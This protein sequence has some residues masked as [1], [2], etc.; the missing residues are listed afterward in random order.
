MGGFSQW[1]D[2]SGWGCST[3]SFF[4]VHS[5]IFNI[6]T[7]YQNGAVLPVLHKNT[8]SPPTLSPPTTKF[9]RISDNIFSGS[10]RV[11]WGNSPESLQQLTD[12][13]S[14]RYMAH[15]F[16]VMDHQENQHV[17]TTRGKK[18]HYK[19]KLTA[20]S[21]GKQFGL[22][23]SYTRMHAHAGKW[24]TIRSSFLLSAIPVRPCLGY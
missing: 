14:L 1:S 21:L 10:F 4:I 20:M 5:F 6:F 11:T 18:V 17:L 8:L 13:G 19:N 16:R 2:F 23:T 7:L 12:P 22:S 24:L 15:V 9:T 3:S